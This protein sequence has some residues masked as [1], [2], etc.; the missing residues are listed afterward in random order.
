[1]T[2]RFV[3]ARRTA[4]ALAVL[5]ILL[6]ALVPSAVPAQVPPK[7]RP[8]KVM[9]RNLYQG[10]NFTE[11]L[12]AQTLPQFLAAVTTTINNVR[13][14]QPAI[15]AMAVAREIAEEQ[16]A[17]VGL[18][19]VATWSTGT[20]FATLAVEI[21]Q[22]ATLLGELQRLGQHY[23]VAQHTTYFAIGAPGLSGVVAVQVAEVILARTDLD[24]G[25]MTVSNASGGLFEA[26]FEIENPILGSLAV[27]RAWVSVDVTIKDRVLRF[28]ATHLDNIDLEVQRQQ[29]E[30]L[31]TGPA[32]TSL[33]VV[34]LGDFN[35]L[36]G[37]PND[38]S[39]PTYATLVAGNFADAWP[40]VNAGEDGL[41]CCHDV[42][43]TDPADTLDTRIDLVLLRGPIAPRRVWLVGERP[44]DILGG[45][46]PSDHAGVVATLLIQ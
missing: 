22:L 35:T 19:E 44:G 16:P 27:P 9:T 38:P 20:S 31:L 1:M 4:R 26:A 8:L 30:E 32:N 12:A 3:A 25:E 46:W 39:Y 2:W 7:G 33:P 28:I 43:L 42:P 21:N 29:A 23:T 15:R 36:P 18:Q 45:F 10:T 17:L 37:D 11:A 34:L 6:I 5:S 41:T 13:A 14:S 24:P 40:Q